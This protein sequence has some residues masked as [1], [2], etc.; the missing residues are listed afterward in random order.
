MIQSKENYLFFLE[1]D[2]KALGRNGIKDYIFDDI[3]KFQRLMRKIEYYENCKNGL[4]NKLILFYLKYKYKK[5]SVLLGFS[6][7]PHTFNYGLNIAH[8]GDIVINGNSK[9]GKYCRVHSGVCIGEVKGKAPIIEDEVYI[10]PGVKI[11]G[12]VRISKGVVLAANSVIVKNIEEKNIT[13]A[14]IPCKKISGNNSSTLLYNGN[15]NEN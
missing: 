8:Y 11:L 14:G 10:G 5:L 15:I 1:E 13:V 2:R 9:I 7:S 12:G 6:I 4:F 3:W